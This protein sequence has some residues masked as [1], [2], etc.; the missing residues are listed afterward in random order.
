MEACVFNDR[1]IHRLKRFVLKP[2]G[3]TGIRSADVFFRTRR[4]IADQR[5]DRRSEARREERKQGDVRC[6][7]SVFP[8]GN[9]RLRHIAKRSDVL[10]GQS[11]TF[12]ISA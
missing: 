12:T 4:F 10:L 9:R 7:Q 2:R 8:F 3:I 5:I 1:L 6:T 11:V